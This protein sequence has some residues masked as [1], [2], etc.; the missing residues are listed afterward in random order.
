VSLK[1]KE[2]GI[3][4]LNNGKLVKLFKIPQNVMEKRGISDDY[5]WWPGYSCNDDNGVSLYWTATGKYY[6][7]H[8]GLSSKEHQLNVSGSVREDVSGFNKSVWF[9]LPPELNKPLPTE[10]H[11]VVCYF[12]CQ[13]EKAADELAE[14]M[15]IVT[16]VQCESTMYEDE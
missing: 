10:K 5:V 3:Y 9:V 4:R 14:A 6:P 16:G 11:G 2:G 12:N 7:R 8:H 1:I 13:T 15:K